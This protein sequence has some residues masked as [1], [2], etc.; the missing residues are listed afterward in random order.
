MTKI[1]IPNSGKR[2]A[3]LVVDLQPSFI[4]SRNSYVI[5]NIRHLIE[6]VPYDAYAYTEFSAPAG[7]VWHEQLNTTFPKE[8]QGELEGEI[9]KLLKSR[10]ALKV[11]K[12]TKSAF[13]GY[14][15][16]REYLRNKEIEEIHIVG[17]DV[18]DCVLASAHEAFDLQ[19]LTYVIEECVQS[20]PSEELLE[21]SIKILR[22]VRLS[23]HSCLKE[24]E[25]TEI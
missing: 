23:N 4:N 15:D 17:L 19:F 25:Y 20:K 12:Q 13:K 1:P 16:L 6:T 24:I 10:K 11:E 9:R 5:A 3:L 14:P 2:K 7:S 8:E 18:H 22:E 21:A